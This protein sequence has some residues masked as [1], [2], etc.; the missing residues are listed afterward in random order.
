MSDLTSPLATI[1]GPAAIAPTE[2]LGLPVADAVGDPSGYT[3]GRIRQ[4]ATTASC[5]AGLLLSLGY[6]KA[7]QK[8]RARI[9]QV[10]GEEEYRRLRKK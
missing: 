3:H 10:V 1:S 2:L 7:G 9:R 4:M 8:T 5:F 6:P